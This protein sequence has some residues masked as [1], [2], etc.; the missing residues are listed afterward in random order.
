MSEHKD[1]VDMS[2][3]ERHLFTMEKRQL[4]KAKVQSGDFPTA[5]RITIGGKDYLAIPSGVSEKGSVAYSLGPVSID[6]KGRP[7][8][9]NKVNISILN[10]G[11]ASFEA[12]DMSQV[13]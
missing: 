2:K 12:I 5:L 6:L 11:E 4:A 8:R 10:T 3:E 1:W 9:I 13:L 7:A